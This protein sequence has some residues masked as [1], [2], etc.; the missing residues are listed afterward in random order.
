MGEED[1]V[2]TA[3]PI[4]GINH[5]RLISSLSPQASLLSLLSVI[6]VDRDDDEERKRKPL[7]MMR[8]PK[9][10]QPPEKPE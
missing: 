9:G 10:Q 2:V 1:A 6:A 4:G 7:V 3:N 8:S 5:G